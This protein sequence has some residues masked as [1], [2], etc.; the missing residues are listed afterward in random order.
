M[1]WAAAVLVV[2]AGGAFGEQAKADGDI[3]DT[4]SAAGQFGTLLTAATKAGLVETLK[5]DGP[6]TVFAPTD[7]AFARVPKATLDALL[8]D[9]AKL[10]EVLLYHV[11]PG[12]VMAADVVK[13]DSAK[14]VQ[15]EPVAIKTQGGKVMVNN[16]EVVK[17]D[18]KA[19]NGII[20]VIDAVLLPP[21]R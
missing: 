17:P 6:L 8:Q 19:S 15:G 1:R 21:A 10:R 9:K 18:I 12:R 3:V 16:A 4:A 20:H 7:Q 14:T 11:V 2:L 13:L 5:G